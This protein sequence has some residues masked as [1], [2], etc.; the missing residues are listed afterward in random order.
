V[1]G[2]RVNA[3][4]RD[5]RTDDGAL[6]ALSEVNRDTLERVRTL[7]TSVRPAEIDRLGLAGA[8]STMLDRAVAGTAL[9]AVSDIGVGDD[10]VRDEDRIH[11]YRIAQEAVTNALKHAGA[12]TLKL[13]L[14]PAGSAI[15]LEV[16]DDGG[17]F[18]VA[19]GHEGFG[20]ASMRERA[21]LLGGNIEIDSR[22]G[23]GTR[24][25]LLLPAVVR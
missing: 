22:P 17:G 10:V 5:G 25:S 7:A 18:D 20:S 16:A 2:N 14:R 15:R 1:L 24:V 13:T 8:L 6:D 23:E 19:R 9:R 21:A 3:L 11:L 12:S 4:R